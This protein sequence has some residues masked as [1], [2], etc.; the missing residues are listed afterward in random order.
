M[1]HCASCADSNTS[2]GLTNIHFHCTIANVELASV[3][4]NAYLGHVLVHM[5]HKHR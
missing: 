5:L 4:T 3:L 1:L 2:Y